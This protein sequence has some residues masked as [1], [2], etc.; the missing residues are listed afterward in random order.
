MMMT[1]S[2]ERKKKCLVKEGD[3]SKPNYFPCVNQGKKKEKI[4]HILTQRN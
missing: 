3:I 1:E 4:G 2:T